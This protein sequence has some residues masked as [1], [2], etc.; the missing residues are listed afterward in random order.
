MKSAHSLGDVTVPVGT[1]IAWTFNTEHTDNATIY[2][3][4]GYIP[5]FL[6]TQLMFMYQYRFMNDTDYTFT[7]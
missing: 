7:F 5:T 4:S 2:F 6:K 3:G 1:K